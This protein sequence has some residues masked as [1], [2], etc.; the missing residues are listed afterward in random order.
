MSI[1]KY[2]LSLNPLWRLTFIFFFTI[3]FLVANLLRKIRVIY[4]LKKHIDYLNQTLKDLENQAKL[5]LK[6]D[7]ELKSYQEEVEDKINKINLLKKTI[8]SSIY[9]LDKDMLF[10]QIE[11]S[12]I[13][14]LGF[15][16][17]LIIDY[18]DLS[19]KVNINLEDYEIETIRKFLYYKKEVFKTTPLITSE[20]EFC[21]ELTKALNY[22]NFLMAPVRAKESIFAI[23]VLLDTNLPDIKK[24][25]KEIF[26]LICVYFG[27]CLD[28]IKLFEELYHIK[29]ELENKVKE[30]AFELVNSLRE[31]EKISKMKSDFISSVS[32][33]LRTPLTSIKGFS[34]LLIEEKFG[35]LP[36][37]AKER[38]IKIDENVNKLVDMV[39]TLLDISRIESG[40]T[41]IKISP[42]DIVKLIKDVCSFL[43]PQI[44]QKEI[45][46]ILD[47]PQVLMVYIDKNFIERVFINII[48]NA[49][50]FTPKKGKITIK[51]K[52]ENTSAL[53]SI[54]DT[55]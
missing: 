40:K 24:I 11:E 51:C 53:I 46:L 45:E 3:L 33:E 27:Q 5:I 47:L 38:L 32:H 2:L 37:E 36:Q 29:E 9:I 15:K 10:N 22:K 35:K 23:F 43:S 30:R 49:I 26:S 12:T 28:N 31:I 8:L 25:E 21:K 52:K 18:T 34:S 13:N 41:E 14:D 50:K 4:N 48:N 16:K 55:G 44:I 42:S 6:E 1:F 54:S 20:N 7:I 17:G 19:A 39:N